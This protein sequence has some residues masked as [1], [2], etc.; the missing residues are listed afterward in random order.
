MLSN[1]DLG[2]DDLPHPSSSAWVSVWGGRGFFPPYEG[3]QGSGALVWPELWFFGHTERD[4]HPESA[5]WQFAGTTRP[6]HVLWRVFD[7]AYDPQ[8]PK[9]AG[10]QSN[11]LLLLDKAPGM[12]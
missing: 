12:S 5:A 10:T 4:D 11:A 7:V 8:N 1:V 9:H 3:F 6:K 2:Y